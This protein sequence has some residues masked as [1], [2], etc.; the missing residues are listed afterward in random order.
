ML[1]ILLLLMGHKVDIITSS[2]VLAERD[3]KEV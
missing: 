2:K 1:A 3:A